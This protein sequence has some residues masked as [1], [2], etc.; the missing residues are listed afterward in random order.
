L[1]GIYAPAP[2]EGAARR[3]PNFEIARRIRNDWRI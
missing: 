1:S 2:M 3:R